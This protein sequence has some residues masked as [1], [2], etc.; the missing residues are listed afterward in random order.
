MGLF[1]TPQNNSPTEFG[2][3]IAEMCP[4]FSSTAQR[5]N[6]RYFDDFCKVGALLQDSDVCER[7][8]DRLNK[9]METKYAQKLKLAI[10]GYNLKNPN[11]QPTKNKFVD[12]LLAPKGPGGFLKPMQMQPASNPP[13]PEKD[14]FKFWGSLDATLNDNESRWGFNKDA[15]DFEK[16]YGSAPGKTALLTGFV[17]PEWFQQNLQKAHRHWKDPMVP[18]GHGEFSHRLQWYIICS[19]QETDFGQKKY[20]LLQSVSGAP[21]LMF[22]TALEKYKL[23]PAPGKAGREAWMWDL[24]VD[25]FYA[26]VPG[27]DESFG[28]TTTFRSPEFMMT[29]F[30]RRQKPDLLSLFIR[31]RLDKRNAMNLNKTNEEGERA[32]EAYV[33]KK[34]WDYGIQQADFEKFAGGTGIGPGRLIFKQ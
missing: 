2:K 12:V 27:A 4:A 6:D 19:E 34:L 15:K 32:S 22:A 29:T 8:L 5:D 9:D 18:E 10:D 14:H 1:K 24:L 11:K 25:S 21:H 13:L 23:D 26:G 17:S 33:V 3:V 30:Q 31:Y 7:N 20:Q 16:S 28:K